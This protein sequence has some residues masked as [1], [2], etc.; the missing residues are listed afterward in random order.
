MAP[1]RFTHTMKIQTM[2]FAVVVAVA[3]T[4]IAATLRIGAFTLP[5]R[6]E[7]TNV[8][9]IVRHV[10]T[11]DVI[12]YNSAITS[13]TPP[14]IE[15]DGNV[16][17]NGEN[18]PDTTLYRPQVFRNGIEFRIENGQTNCIIRQSLTDAAKAIENELP[19]RTNLAHSAQLFID[20]IADG[21]ITNRPIAE[22][23]SRIRVY[24][25]GTLSVVNDT[26][27]SDSIILQNFIYFREHA[28]FLPLSILDSKY[29]Q[30]GTNSFYTIL[31]RFDRPNA[32]WHE[33]SIQVVPLVFADGYWCFCFE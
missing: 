22:L 14:F 24:G 27:G 26:E 7:D 23:R 4:L 10:V 25:N 6:F 1:K 33:R 20:S 16:T 12:S 9:D 21:T 5:Y 11:N 15:K 18:T 30:S 19:T 3:S 28:A 32:P 8:T 31:A 29:L 17:V 2:S 13:F